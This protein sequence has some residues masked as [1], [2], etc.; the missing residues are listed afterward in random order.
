MI[1]SHSSVMG[2]DVEQRRRLIRL[3]VMLTILIGV[4]IALSDLATRLQQHLG[5]DYV[6]KQV[7][8]LGNDPVQVQRFINEQI[9]PADY[10]GFLRGPAATLWAG[11][12]SSLDRAV[13]LMKMLQACG[14]EAQLARSGETWWVDSPAAAPPPGVLEADWR[15]TLVP[16]SASHRLELEIRTGGPDDPLRL[17]LQ[18]AK[19]TDDPLL[20]VLDS[21]FLTVRQPSQ[22]KPL[23]SCALPQACEELQVVCRT[24]LPNDAVGFEAEDRV[25]LHRAARTALGVVE[26]EQPILCGMLVVLTAAPPRNQQIPENQISGRLLEKAVSFPYEVAVGLRRN[27]ELKHGKEGFE[28][29]AN[30]PRHLPRYFLATIPPTDPALEEGAKAGIKVLYDPPL[31]VEATQSVGETSTLEQD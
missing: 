28:P 23:G 21:G 4:M 27:A 26:S 25:L 24:L 9:T 30:W 16:S 15:G 12:G 13:L 22:R 7:E 8:Q 11:S 1:G 10:R 6:A 20:L 2:H 14:E 19:L 29:P 3:A 5:F 31:P 17:E 18:L